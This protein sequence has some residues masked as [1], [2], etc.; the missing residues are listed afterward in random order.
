MFC[1]TIPF[2]LSFI[3]ETPKQL[4]APNQEDVERLN[5]IVR[6]PKVGTGQTPVLILL[7]GYGSNETDLFS[8]V[9]KIPDEWLVV[10]V[11]A[12]ISISKDKFKWYD[13]ALVDN[14]I[15][16]N[17]SHETTSRNLLLQLVNELP[18]KYNIDKNK[19]V[20]AGFSQGAN[21]ALGL[22]LTSPDKIFA[23]ACFSGR[24]LEELRPLIKDK[25]LL[26]DRTVFISHGSEDH[27][28]P[29]KYAEQNKTILEGLGIEVSLAKDKTGHTISNKMQESF[30]QWL[31]RF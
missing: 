5:Y 21:M 12:P 11:R 15:T 30:I 1:A 20:T 23:A 29:M 24:F 26:K 2:L 8:L 25:T 19:I 31:N 7:H 13:V 18:E 6:A 9:E 17:T 22:L 27:L 4:E 28:L 16:M 10:S 3:L 14:L